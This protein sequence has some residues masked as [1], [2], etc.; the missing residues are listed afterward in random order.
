MNKEIVD[1]FKNETNI[2]N[3]IKLDNYIKFIEIENIL[4]YFIEV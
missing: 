2:L 3:Q 4:T 1:I